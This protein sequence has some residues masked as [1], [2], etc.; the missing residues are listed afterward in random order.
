MIDA[1]ELGCLSN[2]DCLNKMD[3]RITALE[4]GGG[5]G[6]TAITVATEELPVPMITTFN[7]LTVDYDNIDDYITDTGLIQDN[8]IMLFNGQSVFIMPGSTKLVCTECT[9][10]NGVARIKTYDISI[11]SI[12]DGYADFTDVCTATTYTIEGS[13]N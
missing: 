13:T 7:G 12:H 3:E 2:L 1:K 8:L 4:E 5:G 10:S 11:V 6:G 9:Q